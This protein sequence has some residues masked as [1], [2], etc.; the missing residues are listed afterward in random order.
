M[1]GKKPLK[2]SEL[3]LSSNLKGKYRLGQTLELAKANGSQLKRIKFKIVAFVKSGEIWSQ[4]TMGT[5][6]SGT[7]QLE[8]Y[9]YVAKSNF[10]GPANLARL[11]YSSLRQD[12]F[13]SKAYA[14]AV[15]QKQAGLTKR[16]ADNG[17]QRLQAMKKQTGQKLDRQESSLKK[18]QAQLALYQQQGGQVTK[19]QLK[20]LQAGLAK[21]QAARKQMA[22]WP[23]PSYQVYT[24]A[25]LPG[26]EGYQNFVSE[27]SSVAA[28]SNVFPVVLYLVAAL[29]VLTTMTRFVDEERQN[30]GI[31][32]ALGYNKRDV[33]QKFIIYGLVASTAGS[34]LGILLG[35]YF[36]SPIILRIV[37]MGSVIDQVPLKLHLS[38]VLFTLAA[39]L[40]TAVL[41]SLWVARRELAEQPASLLLPKAPVAGSKILLERIK[42]LWRRLS[43]NGKV[44][45]RNIFRYKQRMLMTIFGVAGSV[46]LLFTG[47]GIRSSISGIADRQFGQLL[48]YDL[49]V[50]KNPQASQKAQKE[51]KAKL[52]SNDVERKLPVA[53]YQLQEKVQGSDEAQ[54]VSLIVSQDKQLGGL[55]KLD[56]RTSGK[57]LQLS[58][59]G[60]VVSEKLASLAQVKPGEALRVKINGQAAKIKIAAVCEMY[61]GHAIYMSADYYEKATGKKYQSNASLVDL[62]TR[63]GQK[64][65]QFA[66]R[67][68]KLA[69]CGA[70][71]QNQSQV[72]TLKQVVNSLQTVMIVLSLLS[73]MLA[74]VILYNLTNINVAERIRELSTI[75]VLG[76][77]NHEVTM[78]IYRETIALSL[79]GII[80]GII[81]GKGMHRLIL[82]VI[83]SSQIMFNPRVDLFVYLAPIGAI[84]LILCLL[85]LWVDRTLQ[86]VDML[87]ALKSVD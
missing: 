64:I 45:A 7:G 34:V 56:E 30:A 6:S 36:I 13:A 31:F 69:A 19:K 38:L 60:A 84:I 42:P 8:G 10:A 58:Q 54:A 77:H 51:L 87:E 73:V 2:K 21:I 66:A 20:Q 71:S 17:D 35:N 1:Q 29:V 75:K 53:F 79:A 68:L 33:I 43:F 63:S 61:A 4:E 72:K 18:Q 49:L 23:K 24:R 40:A 27:I 28:V 86:K 47:L 48:R 9:A 55:V 70:V 57:Q 83:G 14:K 37:C 65:S 25:S 82:Q 80:A 50:V 3:A 59:N 85:C 11:R 15:S 39:G 76:F 81:L 78:Y 5:A 67:C 41:P 16:L 46:A 12:S 22:K 32:R 62:K 44:T 26:G 52:A 74:V